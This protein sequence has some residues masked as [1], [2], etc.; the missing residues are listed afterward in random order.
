[1]HSRGYA[2]GISKSPAI[3]EVMLAG[4]RLIQT[5]PFKGGQAGNGGVK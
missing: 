3:G 4:E 1:M 5:F 2:E